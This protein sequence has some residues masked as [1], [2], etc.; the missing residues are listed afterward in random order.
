MTSTATRARVDLLAAARDHAARPDKW[1]DLV[2]FDRHRRWY[3][4]VSRDS[5]TEVWLLSWLPGQGTDLHDHG[6]S[7]GAFVVVDGTLTEDTAMRTP[8]GLTVTETTVST[9]QGRRFGPRYVH[10]I[11]NSGATPAVSI[12]AY[13]PAL[14]AMNRYRLAAGGLQIVA[15]ERA[16]VSW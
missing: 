10:R 12:H 1:R 13:G 14:T 16:G 15:V 4:R 7:A 8:A 6:G 3:A 9:G 5:D 11:T 2:R